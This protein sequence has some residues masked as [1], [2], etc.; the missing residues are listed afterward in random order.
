MYI[1]CVLVLKLVDS[2]VDKIGK[3]IISYYIIN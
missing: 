2:D 1:D 3:D